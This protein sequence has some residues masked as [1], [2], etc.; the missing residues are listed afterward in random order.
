VAKNTFRPPPTGERAQDG[1]DD[2]AIMEGY[3]A[4][5]ERRINRDRKNKTKKM[6]QTTRTVGGRLSNSQMI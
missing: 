3:L 4:R 2:G 1:Y 5:S 6:M